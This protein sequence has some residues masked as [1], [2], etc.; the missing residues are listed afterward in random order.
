LVVTILSDVVL[1]PSVI[2]VA[3][4]SVEDVIKPLSLVVSTLK[5]EAEVLDC[6][7]EGKAEG[8]AVDG[9]FVELTDD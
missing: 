5:V 1:D 2:K 9:K 3:L 6:A 7:V 4:P 8:I